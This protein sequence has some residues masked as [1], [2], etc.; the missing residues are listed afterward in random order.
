MSAP[1]LRDRICH[2]LPVQKILHTA[3]SEGRE[4]SA[5]LSPTENEEGRVRNENWMKGEFYFRALVKIKSPYKNMWQ[6]SAEFYESEEE[7]RK[8]YGSDCKWP[9]EDLDGVIFCPD[10][11]ELEKKS[12]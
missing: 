1:P 3:A 5:S 6:L 10:L 7:A 12:S 11:E 9:A 4:N 2:L 8:T